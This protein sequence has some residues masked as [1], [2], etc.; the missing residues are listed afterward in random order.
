MTCLTF[1]RIC[2]AS[3]STRPGSRIV[4]LML[5]GNSIEQPFF[6]VK[7]DPFGCRCALIDCQN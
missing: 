2:N 6:L 3:C 4:L 1:S 7:E 5:H